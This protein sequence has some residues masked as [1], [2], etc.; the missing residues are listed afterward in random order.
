MAKQTPN[1]CSLTGYAAQDIRPAHDILSQHHDII[2]SADW[3]SVRPSTVKH[4][5][6]FVGLA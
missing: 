6:T 2:Y 3:T 1:V 4:G 5:C